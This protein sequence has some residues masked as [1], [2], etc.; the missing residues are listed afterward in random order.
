MN[1]TYSGVLTVRGIAYDPQIRIT[2]LDL[3]IDGVSHGLISI[4][5]NR[6]DVCS[7]E[8]LRGCPTIGFVRQIDLNEFG[9]IPVSIRCRFG[10]RTAADRRQRFPSSRL[11]SHSKAV[12][13]GSC[14]RR[15]S[16]CERSS[17]VCND[18][19]SW[20]RVCPRPAHHSRRGVDR[21]RQLRNCDLR[22][23]THRYL[24]RD[25]DPGSE[26]SEIGFQF[27]LN[28]VNGDVQF[29]TARTLFRSASRMRADG[30]RPRRNNRS[31]SM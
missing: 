3:L 10:R 13:P 18:S 21:R 15:G 14:R 12:K 31:L 19:D 5:E 24:Q 17:V 22:C 28:T 16:S 8:P 26:L 20:I 4:T 29:R 11:R 27:S 25:G 1:G 9:S 2:R 6:T 7:A 30:L 23:P